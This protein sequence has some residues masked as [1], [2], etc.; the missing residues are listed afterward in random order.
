MFLCRVR[1]N[2]ALEKGDG[3]KVAKVGI[4]RGFDVGQNRYFCNIGFLLSGSTRRDHLTLCLISIYL[5]R[6]A[7]K[8]LLG[9]DR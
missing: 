3:Q 4:K 7:S 5:E 8:A 2:E 1:K 6:V 9:T